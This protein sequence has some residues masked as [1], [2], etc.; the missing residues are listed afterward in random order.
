MTHSHASQ[1]YFIFIFPYYRRHN[2]ETVQRLPRGSELCWSLRLNSFGCGGC[3]LLT[4][5][6]SI[7]NQLQHPILGDSRAAAVEWLAGDIRRRRGG[8]PT[9]QWVRS[10]D[11][12]R[13]CS[14]SP[15]EGGKSSTTYKHTVY[16]RTCVHAYLYTLSSLRSSNLVSKIPV[17]ITASGSTQTPPMFLGRRAHLEGISIFS[18]A[19]DP[20]TCGTCHIHQSYPRDVFVLARIARQYI[21]PPPS[22]NVAVLCALGGQGGCARPSPRSFSETRGCLK[23]SQICFGGRGF[24]EG[25]Q[26]P[27]HLTRHPSILSGRCTCPGSPACL[28]AMV[29]C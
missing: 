19:M 8:L 11:R 1:A 29:V 13:C 20:D 3:R 28:L 17:S 22:P 10:P 12:R 6:D 16:I 18:L 25:I 15:L 7:P 2:G 26:K 9:L 24:G 23:P 27:R 21:A 4:H 14:P 5:Q